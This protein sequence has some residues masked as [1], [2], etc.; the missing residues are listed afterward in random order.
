MKAIIST[1]THGVLD[2][3]TVGFA[4]AFPRMFG[5]SRGFTRAVTVIALG[6]LTYTLFTRHELGLFKCIPMKAHLAMDALGGAALCALPWA[7]DEEN[8]AA[9]AAAVGM[10]L[11]DIAAAPMTQTKAS[12]DRFEPIE[13]RI[14]I[15][16][17]ST[18]EEH[19]M[20]VAGVRGGG[21]R[22]G[23]LTE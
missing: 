8:S 15:E 10:G 13:R 22:E 5:A 19:Q 14:P 6:K 21:L 1:R 20:A 9:C 7:L 4:L 18:I 17:T 11:F 23:D 16:G 12:F 3:L 2:Y